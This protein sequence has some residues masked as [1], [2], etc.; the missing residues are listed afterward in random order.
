MKIIESLLTKNP[1][2]T[3][4]ET[5]VVE[6]FM[7]HSIGCPQP[8]A[9]VFVKNWNKTSYN[10]A[11][12][13]AF[14]D[15]NTGDIYQTLPWNHRGW[16]AGGSANDTHIGVEMCEP[17]CIK[18]TRGSSFTCSDLE[19]ARA[20]VKRTYESAVELFA[21]L[22]KQYNRDPLADGVIV[23]HKEGHARG[24]ASNHGDPEHLWKGLGL[25][26]TMDTFRQAVKASMGIKE[27]AKKPSTTK[28]K[29]AKGDKVKVK[30][31]VTYDGK[32]FKAYYDVYDVIDVKDDRVVIGIGKTVTAAVKATNL[33]KTDA[34]P[35]K[36][37]IKVGC[38]VR[39]REGA[40]TF[41]GGSLASFVYDRDH[42]VKEINVDRVVITYNKI[43]VAAVRKSDLIVID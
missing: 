17:A 21:F 35:V 27:P 10:K 39:L 16:H 28:A 2:Y 20:V 30:K 22:C 19:E 42:Q 1:C 11:C 6:G 3:A 32:S 37:E 36:K 9:N 33:T 41:Q 8:D 40:K 24:I 34:E 26:Y 43:V 7:L 23:S 18:Y 29:F 12:V 15:G 14:I 4:G 5:I 31:A 38:T 25:P 13:H